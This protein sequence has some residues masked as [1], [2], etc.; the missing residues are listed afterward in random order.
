MSCLL[1]LA[2][3]YSSQDEFLMAEGVEQMSCVVSRASLAPSLIMHTGIGL[4]L[5]SSSACALYVLT[6]IHMHA[7]QAGTSECREWT[8]ISQRADEPAVAIEHKEI[9]SARLRSSTGESLGILALTKGRASIDE[10]KS[11]LI[12]AGDRSGPKLLLRTKTRPHL[13]SDF[14]SKIVQVEDALVLA[15]NCCLKLCARQHHCIALAP[16]LL[17]IHAAIPLVL[18]LVVL[19]LLL[20][21]RLVSHEAARVRVAGR[22]R[23]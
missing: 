8:Q 21:F 10:Q 22:Q 18:S 3:V 23:C 9:P 4:M 14:L 19:E 15:Q 5:G 2:P 6:R 20:V 16:S 1:V 12:D 7:L 11:L 13:T 17:C